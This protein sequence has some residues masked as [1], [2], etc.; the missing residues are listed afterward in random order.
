M[1]LADRPLNQT[2]TLIGRT[3]TG[4]MDRYGTPTWEES[5]AAVACWVYPIDTAEVEDRAAGRFT[6]R[7]FFP[8]GTVVDGF[9]QLQVDGQ[10]WDL[11][12]P[13]LRWVNP[14]DGE[15]K[16]VVVDLVGFTDIEAEE[17]S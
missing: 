4:P 17:S 1:S 13:P 6:H 10:Q 16:F 2:G 5:T 15:E 9:A 11:D 14:R 7:A 3:Q 8:P 12:G